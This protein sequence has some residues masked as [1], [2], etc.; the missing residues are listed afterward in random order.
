MG[1]DFFL[2]EL[3]EPY[4]QRNSPLGCLS[5][6]PAGPLFLSEITPSHKP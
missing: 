3:L 2:P 5:A 1:M 4:G 6:A